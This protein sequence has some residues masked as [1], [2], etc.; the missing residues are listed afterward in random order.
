MYQKYDYTREMLKY[1]DIVVDGQFEADKHLVDLKFRGSYNQR[2]IDVQAS[3]KQNKLIR[4]K[5]G[6]EDRYAEEIKNPKI[7]KEI[8]TNVEE[9]N[10]ANTES[11][12]ITFVPEFVNNSNFV[13]KEVEENIAAKPIEEIKLTEEAENILKINKRKNS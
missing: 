7:Y 8:K 1:I 6:D 3:I 5:F 11:T 4:L 12:V 2:K 10:N 13:E 9:N